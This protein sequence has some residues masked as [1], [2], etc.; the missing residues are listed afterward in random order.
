MTKRLLLMVWIALL[1]LV[2]L[3]SLLPGSVMPRQP[4]GG[5]AE[6][7]LAYFGLGVIPAALMRSWRRLVGVVLLVIS[8]GALLE[9]LQRY[10]PGRSCEI[11]DLAAD[12][13]GAIL[14]LAAG[15]P[16]R[17]KVSEKL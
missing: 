3:F 14:G 15:L 10:I 6:H 17:R 8:M 16:W 13:A 7:F 5:A 12:G 9:L 4:S 1:G 11:W 2:I